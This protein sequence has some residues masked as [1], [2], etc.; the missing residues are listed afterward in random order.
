MCQEKSS[1]LAE[2]QVSLFGAH[3]MT[4]D[5]LAIEKLKTECVCNER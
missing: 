1:A 4:Q 3:L 5:E 2:R